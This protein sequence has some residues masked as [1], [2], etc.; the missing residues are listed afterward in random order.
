MKKN[1]RKLN[2]LSILAIA[3]LMLI[4]ISTSTSAKVTA[5]DINGKDGGVYEYNFEALKISAA[6][7]ILAGNDACAPGA[8]LYSHLLANK[9]TTA[10][11]YDDVKAAYVDATVVENAAVNAKLI[12]QKFNLNAFTSATS[13]PTITLTSKKVVIGPNGTV[14]VD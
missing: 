6:A 2:V 1:K 9:S 3:G 11:Y 12:G 7:Y 14:P 8:Q 5:I 13:T 10:A 4:G